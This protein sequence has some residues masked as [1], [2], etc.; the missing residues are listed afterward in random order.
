MI[1]AAPC[2]G[3]FFAFSQQIKAIRFHSVSEWASHNETKL[4]GRAATN[5]QQQ[6]SNT[7]HLGPEAN[8]NTSSPW[9]KDKGL[10]KGSLPKGSTYTF[11]W[12][13]SIG[14]R[15]FPHPGGHRAVLRH[16]EKMVAP[17][18][19]IMVAWPCFGQEE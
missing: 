16:P 17:A 13:T 1:R 9:P 10:N 15:H 11:A 12:L 14:A 4:Q 2:S 7:L 6:R 18:P 5:A 3:L 8:P 19:D